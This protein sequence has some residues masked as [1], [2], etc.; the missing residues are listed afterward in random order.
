VIGSLPSSSRRNS[1]R[2]RRRDT[3]V[4]RA[5]LRFVGA[6]PVA[7]ALP[8]GAGSPDLRAKIWRLGLL[9]APFELRWPEQKSVKRTTAPSNNL[10][11]S[12]FLQVWI[13]SAVLSPLSGRGGMA[14]W[15]GVAGLTL[16]RDEGALLPPLAGRGGR[17]S[18]RR[19]SERPCLARKLIPGAVA[20]GPV[21]PQPSSPAGRGGEGRSGR[22]WTPPACPRR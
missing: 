11:V 13:L 7:G 4:D 21:L 20:C 12:V 19:S 18:G 3:G 8:A 15:S 5:R 1:R 2:G 17:G 16:V 14:R 22:V 6:L 9:L 10:A